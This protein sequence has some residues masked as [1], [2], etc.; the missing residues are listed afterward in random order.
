MRAG[1]RNGGNGAF[2]G[3]GLGGRRDALLRHGLA[4]RG[5]GIWLQGRGLGRFGDGWWPSYSTYVGRLIMLTAWS[6]LVA[7]T[8]CL[9]FC[10]RC[11]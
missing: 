5:V 4:G 6:F 10:Y 11:V 7:A 9:S 2:A 1:G 3:A 8:P